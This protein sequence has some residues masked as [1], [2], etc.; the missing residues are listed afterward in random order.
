MLFT[1][2]F[3]HFLFLRYLLLAEHHFLSDILV[4]FPDSSNLYSCDRIKKDS[5]SPVNL[6]LNNYSTE[7]APTES[8]A[9]GTL[10]YIN[11]RLSSQLRNDLRIYDPGKI[12]STFIEIICSKLTNMIVG[13]MYKYP[14]LPIK[15]FTMNLFLLYY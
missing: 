6:Q 4:P 5:S 10:F 15:D 7:H 2:L 9:G 8:L 3:Y 11:K 13:C 12:E 1:V 14:A